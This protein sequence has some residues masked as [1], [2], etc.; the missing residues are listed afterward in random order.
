MPIDA[1]TIDVLRKQAIAMAMLWLTA[2]DYEHEGGRAWFC[3]R[4]SDLG[5]RDDVLPGKR[6]R[7]TIEAGP[8]TS[9]AQEVVEGQCP[10][11]NPDRFCTRKE[12]TTGVP[13]APAAAEDR[14]L[15]PH[16]RAAFER[17]MKQAWGMVNPL[18]PPG[19]P[20][21]YARGE[22]NGICAALQ[23]VRENFARELAADSVALP[24]GPLA[25]V[26]AGIAALDE[27]HDPLCMAVLRGKACT[28]GAQEANRG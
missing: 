19:Q 27:G 2:R 3:V 1:P 10:N 22:H 9:G 17:A 18:I 6:I 5:L 11:C 16:A 7:V 15:T 12:C 25:Q 14:G 13:A 20:G 23:T 24:A 8:D 26:A 4:A 28:C 21:S